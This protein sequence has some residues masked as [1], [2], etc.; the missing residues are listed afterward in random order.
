MNL[1]EVLTSGLLF[2]L[3]AAASL[4]LWSLGATGSVRDGDRQLRLDRL[5]AELLGSEERLRQRARQGDA[6]S[7]CREAVTNLA[8]YL[9]AVP[10]L[11]DVERQQRATPDGRL[12]LVQVTLPSEAISRQRLYSPAALGLCPALQEEGHGPL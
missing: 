10:A 2:T 1:V 4:Q 5:E 7:S 6:G 9:A 12:L 8:E 3:A 11:A